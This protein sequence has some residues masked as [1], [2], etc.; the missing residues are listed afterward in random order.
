VDLRLLN[1]LP[2]SALFLNLP[3]QF[4]I[5]N[6]LISVYTQFQHLFLVV[7]LVDFLEDCCYIFK[8]LSFYCPFY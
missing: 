5:L 7:P 6:L 4:L 1:G 3:F 2:Q 8:L